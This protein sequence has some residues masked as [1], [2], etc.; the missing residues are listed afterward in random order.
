MASIINVDQIDEATSGNGV[1]IPGH[2][3]QHGLVEYS[4]GTGGTQS[5]TSTSYTDITGATISYTPKYS[6]SKCLITFN[7]YGRIFAPSGQDAAAYLRTH[8]NGSASK[9]YYV[10]GDNLGKLGDSVWL[11]L[12]INISQEFTTS[13]TSAV[14]F[15]MQTKADANGNYFQVPHHGND[16]AHHTIS[17]LEIAQ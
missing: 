11:P 13:G 16:L 9:E 3:V 7:L 4:I 5:Y 6:G 2:V 1:K 8:I 17:V 15:K 14:V 12:F 10:A